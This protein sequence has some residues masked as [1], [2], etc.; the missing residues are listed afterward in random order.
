MAISLSASVLDSA[1]YAEQGLKKFQLLGKQQSACLFT[2]SFPTAVVYSNAANK[3]N[4][5]RYDWCHLVENV[6]ELLPSMLIS[7][8]NI[9]R[10][11]I[12][13]FL[14]IN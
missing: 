12:G 2:D 11:R 5:L 9:P 10:N 8:V 14:L 3:L 6:Q 1:S 13:M 7:F 4:V